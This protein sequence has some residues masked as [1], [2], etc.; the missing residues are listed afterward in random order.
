MFNKTFLLILVGFGIAGLFV[1]GV[2]NVGVSYYSP[3]GEY[4]PPA[5][6][7]ASSAGAACASSASASGP[8]AASA[9]SASA[10]SA[11]A[12]ASDANYTPSSSTAPTMTAEELVD[13]YT[14]NGEINIGGLCSALEATWDGDYGYKVLKVV[15]DRKVKGQFNSPYAMRKVLNG[16]FS[17]AYLQKMEEAATAACGANGDRVWYGLHFELHRRGAGPLNDGTAICAWMTDPTKIFNKFKD[18]SQVDYDDLGI[19]LFIY[20]ESR[21]R[22]VGEALEWIALHGQGGAITSTVYECNSVTF[23]RSIR[24]TVT[25]Q[26]VLDAI[27]NRIDQIEERVANEVSQTMLGWW[28]Y[29]QGNPLPN[30]PRNLSEVCSHLSRYIQDSGGNNAEFAVKIFMAMRNFSNAEHNQTDSWA[31]YTTL[32]GS[33]ASFLRNQNSAEGT[34]AFLTRIWNEM[35]VQPLPMSTLQPMLDQIANRIVSYGGTRPTPPGGYDDIPEDD[36]VEVTSAQ[37]CLQRYGTNYQAMASYLESTKLYE[38]EFQA[39]VLSAVLGRGKAHLL[40]L[41]Q[42]MTKPNHLKDV[43]EKAGGDVEKYVAGRVG[44]LKNDGSGRRTAEGVLAY[45]YD[46]YS[47]MGEWLEGNTRSDKF[48]LARNT[49]QLL[50]SVRGRR[51]CMDAVAGWGADILQGVARI[52]SDDNVMSVLEARAAQL[53]TPLGGGIQDIV[54][55]C[56]IDDPEQTDPAY[57]L[58]SARKFADEVNSYGDASLVVEALVVLLADSQYGGITVVVDKVLPLLNDKT[59]I[60]QAVWRSNMIVQEHKYRIIEKLVSLG[61]ERPGPQAGGSQGDIN[62]DSKAGRDTPQGLLDYYGSD[63]KT[64]MEWLVAHKKDDPEFCAEVFSK[65]MDGSRRGMCALAE[66]LNNLYDKA[67]LDAVRKKTSGRIKNMITARIDEL[68]GQ[69]AVNTAEGLITFYYNGEGGLDFSGIANAVVER[70]NATM[71]ARVLE[72]IL[73]YRGT[74]W[75][76]AILQHI[77]D[78]AFLESIMNATENEDLQV[79]ISQKLDGLTYD[80]QTLIYRNS[81]YDPMTGEFTPD[82]GAI[83]AD[84]ARRDAQ[85][86]VDF[87]VYFCNNYCQIPGVAL[88]MSRKKS[89]IADVGEA[90]AGSKRIDFLTKAWSLI[91][92]DLSISES[93]RRDL[94]SAVEDAVKKGY[95]SEGSNGESSNPSEVHRIIAQYNGYA[96]SLA[97]ALGGKDARFCAEVFEA[98]LGMG[99]GWD[100]LCDVVSNFHNK[101]ELADIFSHLTSAKAKKAVSQRARI[102]GGDFSY[103]TEQF[104]PG[105]TSAATDTVEGILDHWGSQFDKLADDLE[106][107]HSDDAEFIADVLSELLGRYGRKSL[108]L[109]ISYFKEVNVLEAV[110]GKLASDMIKDMVDGRIGAITQTGRGMNSAYGIILHYMKDGELETT[111]LG[112][113]L[114]GDQKPALAAKTLEA[115]LLDFD[116]FTVREV[117][118]DINDA[119]FIEQIMAKTENTELFALLAEKLDRLG[120]DLEYVVDLGT[121]SAVQDLQRHNDYRYTADY[122]V[123][124]YLKDNNTQT[125]L[126]SVLDAFFAPMTTASRKA[127]IERVWK[128]IRAS[129]Y[130]SKSQRA[131]LKAFLESYM[132]G[133]KLPSGA[134]NEPKT[135]GDR[136]SDTRGTVEG[137]LKYYGNDYMGMA[138]YLHEKNNVAFAGTILEKI[139]KDYGDHTAAIFLYAI[140]DT[141][142]LNNVMPF[143]SSVPLKQMVQERCNAIRGGYGYG[144]PAGGYASLPDSTSTTPLQQGLDG[145]GDPTSPTDTPAGILVHFG[146]NYDGLAKELMKRDAKFIMETLELLGSMKGR[147]AVDSLLGR[148]LALPKEK[149]DGTEEEQFK[150]YEEAGKKIEEAFEKLSDALSFATNGAVR[151]AVVEYLNDISEKVGKF[152]DKVFLKNPEDVVAKYGDNY[153]KIGFHIWGR[154]D[155]EFAVKVLELLIQ[156]GKSNG[157]RQAVESIMNSDFLSQIRAKAVEMKASNQIIR[158]IDGWIGEVK[159]MEE[160]AAISETLTR[161]AKQMHKL[162]DYDFNAKTISDFISDNRYGSSGLEKVWQLVDTYASYFANDSLKVDALIKTWHAVHGMTNVD[163]ARRVAMLN[164]LEIVIRVYGGEPPVRDVTMYG[165]DPNA[166][167]SSAE[168]VLAYF[169]EDYYDMAKFLKL[170]RDAELTSDTLERLV[171]VRDEV[172]MVNVLN[173]ISDIR[174]LLKVIETTNVSTINMHIQQ[175]IAEI[176]TDEKKLLIRFKTEFGQL[177]YSAIAQELFERFDY[178]Y[179]A[180]IFAL[181]IKNKDFGLDGVGKIGS[182]L[183][184]LMGF[185]QPGENSSFFTGM[186][187]YVRGSLSLS[188]E[189]KNTI[190]SEIGKRINGMRYDV[191]TD[192]VSDV[193]NYFGNDFAGMAFYMMQ[194]GDISFASAVFERIYNDKGTG[195]VNAA[196]DTV[197]QFGGDLGFLVGVMYQVNT[198]Y[199]HNLVKERV[200]WV[201]L[202]L[203]NQ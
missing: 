171:S 24:S 99:S 144:A 121:D 164:V 29:E 198:Q 197:E 128:L 26:T 139:F 175:R 115:V 5:A 82:W 170:N 127:F 145:P 149:T 195:A 105:N 126:K 11:S 185:M 134:A 15:W 72:N 181:L 83:A 156:N 135:L 9:S 162:G 28:R 74:D 112:H 90:L 31:Y 78:R 8:S 73:R 57:K 71:A 131:V 143:I 93:V 110:K 150:Y 191:G 97:N 173:N 188:K 176:K 103:T 140:N 108:I 111:R 14:S 186:W 158:Y 172:A 68:N 153:T 80:F 94:L 166:D 122:I 91:K 179:A 56:L 147:S 88:D 7:S 169:G 92:G 1:L 104:T 107:H 136:S 76:I 12:A 174:F 38:H 30:D 132:D 196:L 41:L 152:F 161:L 119:M 109:C 53:N 50:Y 125:M 118:K 89:I 96:K 47:A 51:A 4:I 2:P 40:D 154:G 3:G 120:K 60:A 95:G 142:F 77:S 67:F 45:Y 63:Y 133:A 116:E 35:Y 102:L 182:V 151:S 193:M 178:A 201:N 48:S 69:R 25:N 113:H 16:R 44:K 27:K 34:C 42:H 36:S 84:L 202:D 49:L 46:Q 81:T 160:A 37:T 22:L 86:L 146:T 114:R 192:G 85:Y 124:R 6:L 183:D 98:I 117:I 13:S 203:Y 43:G 61:A 20:N 184:S 199:L 79:L 32:V 17:L 200:E 180:D 167:P 159:L 21:P 66:A 168:G 138:K 18:G 58:F 70:H 59:G 101:D 65:I 64:M 130:V 189:E 137:F 187:I 39:E 177:N 123:R 55:R 100:F 54:G 194:V 155:A 23:L 141:Q 157:A 87:I 33:Y 165:G 106:R 62:G 10:A 52:T 19:F 148:M 129:T 75:V 163:L 190:E